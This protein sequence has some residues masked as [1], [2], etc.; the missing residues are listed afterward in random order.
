MEVHHC[1]GP[2][3]EREEGEGCQPEKVRA[4]LWPL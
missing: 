4:P 3:E 1:R 2:A